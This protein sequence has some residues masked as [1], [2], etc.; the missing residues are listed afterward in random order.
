MDLLLLGEMMWVLFLESDLDVE[1]IQEV[2]F[3]M[4][5][6]LLDQ[7]LQDSSSMTS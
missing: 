2:D 4:R 7:K 3:Q 6:L 1:S 5:L